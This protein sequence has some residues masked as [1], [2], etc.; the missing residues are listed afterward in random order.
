MGDEDGFGRANNDGP[1]GYNGRFGGGM[2]E[3]ADWAMDSANEAAGP[4]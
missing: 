3:G 2:A 4:G 1:G